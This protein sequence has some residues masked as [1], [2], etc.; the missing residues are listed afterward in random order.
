MSI[1]FRRWL[2]AQSEDKNAPRGG[3]V[4][5]GDDLADQQKVEELLR[6]LGVKNYDEHMFNA[7]LSYRLLNKAKLKQFGEQEWRHDVLPYIREARRKEVLVCLGIHS[8]CSSDHSSNSNNS[9]SQS[10]VAVD[11]RVEDLM[12]AYEETLNYLSLKVVPFLQKQPQ[13]Q[14]QAQQDVTKQKEEDAETNTKRKKKQE[15]LS[16]F[17]K[18]QCEKKRSLFAIPSGEIARRRRRRL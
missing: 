7:F 10:S 18:S 16:D 1:F 5:I 12:D 17:S 2:Q 8:D 13:Q 3:G 4:V 9:S 6:D 15:S 11:M 14:A